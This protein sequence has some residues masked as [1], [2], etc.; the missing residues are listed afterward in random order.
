MQDANKNTLLSNAIYMYILF[1]SLIMI[2]PHPRNRIASKNK[3]SFID[4]FKRESYFLMMMSIVHA[5][6]PRFFS[7]KLNV[8]FF[9]SLCVS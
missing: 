8:S 2:V 7:A 4:D 9:L 1:S 5:N 3:I 6:K